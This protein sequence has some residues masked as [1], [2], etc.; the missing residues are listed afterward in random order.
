MR[1]EDGRTYGQKRVPQNV[2]IIVHAACK[3][4]MNMGM[5]GP[6][7]DI[8]PSFLSEMNIFQEACIQANK[9][10]NGRYRNEKELN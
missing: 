2:I 8:S 9:D 4:C 5:L 6:G 10:E 3:R 7:A 1:G